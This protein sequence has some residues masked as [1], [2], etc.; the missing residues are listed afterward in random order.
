MDNNCRKKNTTCKPGSVRLSPSSSFI[1]ATYPP[2]PDGPPFIPRERESPV[3]MVLQPARFSKASGVA[4]A[5]GGLL[6]HLFT[7]TA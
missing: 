7:F 6:L 2:G 5:T 1:Y 3:Y 4:T